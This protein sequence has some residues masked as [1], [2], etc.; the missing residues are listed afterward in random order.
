MREVKIDETT[1]ANIH[2]SA[3]TC[4][5]YETEFN[6][7]DIV[8]DMA[9][10]GETPNF[11]ILRRML[12]ATMKTA[13]PASV[14]KY[15]AWLSGAANLNYSETGWMAGVLEEC[16]AAFFRTAAEPSATAE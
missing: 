10:M 5:L 4:L 16:R 15:S 11:G 1:A 14:P 13:N 8:T 2:A 7:A 9:N 3:M 6:G 12:W